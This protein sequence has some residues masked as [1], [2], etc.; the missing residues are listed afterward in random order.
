MSLNRCLFW[1]ETGGERIDFTFY[2]GFPIDWP[3]GVDGLTATI[4]TN[5]SMD[6]VG[7]EI[8]LAQVP[9]RPINITG[10]IN[11]PETREQER[12]LHRMFAPLKKGRLY[13]R[14]AEHEVF[15]LDCYSA[16]EPTVQGKRRFPRFLVQITAGYPYWQAE[17]ARKI[18]LSLVG[19]GSMG[20]AVVESDVDAVYSAA[21]TCS[22]GSCKNLALTDKSTDMGLHYNGSLADGE[23]LV[24]T[25]SEFGRVTAAI[26]GESMIGLVEAD[27]KKLPAGTRTL[28]LTAEESSGTVTAEITYKEA[29]AGV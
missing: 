26:G 16:A 20:A 19:V 13:A 24:V 23:R 5:R 9:E 1:Y 10:Y 12:K 21:F 6:G 3:S 17:E 7:A 28:G 8:Q 22:G 15:Y 11:T 4:S 29:R 25:I 14:T 18:T 2:G 27:L